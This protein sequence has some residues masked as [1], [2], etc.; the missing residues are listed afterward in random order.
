MRQNLNIGTAVQHRGLILKWKSVVY[1]QFRYEQNA[2]TM[3]QF[4]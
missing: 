2:V 3:G 4:L 1:Q